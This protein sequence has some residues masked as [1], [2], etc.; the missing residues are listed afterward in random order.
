MSNFAATNRWMELPIP[1]YKHNNGQ[2]VKKIRIIATA[3][4]IFPSMIIYQNSLKIRE[5]NI[6]WHSYL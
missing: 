3:I 5:R 1:K 6:K 4:P 2:I